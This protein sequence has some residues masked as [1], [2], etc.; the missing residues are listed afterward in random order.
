MSYL[1]DNIKTLRLAKGLTQLELAE[2]LGTSRSSISL[3]E[4]GKRKPTVE[5]LSQLSSFFNVSMDI[6]VGMEA[7]PE[8]KP[9]VSLSAADINP[10]YS[11]D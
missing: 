4:T 8:L 2:I 9:N 10:K 11:I 7:M 6:L 5:G 3:Y 1:G